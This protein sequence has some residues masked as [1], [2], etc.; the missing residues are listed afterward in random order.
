MLNKSNN[1]RR[2]EFIKGSATV[3]VEIPDDNI[4]LIFI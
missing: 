1:G 4:F 3:N 2:F